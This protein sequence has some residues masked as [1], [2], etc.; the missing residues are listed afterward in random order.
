MLIEGA[1]EEIIEKIKKSE[2]KD[3]KVVK[4]VKEMEKAG[5]KVLR[6]NDWH[7]KDDL[8]LKK[9]KMYV[10][11]NESLGLEIIWPHY[12]TLIARYRG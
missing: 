5:I 3:N 1:E 2:T 7:I 4:V 6:K 10:P 9:R 11:K 8:V 12:D